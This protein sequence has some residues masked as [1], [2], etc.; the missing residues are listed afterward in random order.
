MVAVERGKEKAKAKEYKDDPNVEF[1]EVNG[2]YEAFAT[3]TNDPKVGS[4][5]QYNNTK[6]STTNKGDIDAYEAWNGGSTTTWDGGTTGVSST[7]IAILDTGIKEEHEDLTGKVTKRVNY[8]DSSTNDDV[9]GHGTHVAGSAAALTNN[10]KGV[11]GTCPSC[12]L[13]NVKV[14]GDTGSGYNSWIANGI[15]WATDNGAQVINMSLGGSSSSSTLQSAVDYAWSKGVIVVAAAGN[16]NTNAQHY[17]AAYTNAIAVG[18]TDDTD[19]KASFSNYGSSWVDVAAP[20]VGI[21]STTNDGGYQT[22][23]GTSMA[24]PHVAGEA[25]LIWS[26]SGLCSTNTCVRNQIESKADQTSGTGTYWAKGRVNANGGLGDDTTTDPPP[27]DTTTDPPASDTTAPVA[28]APAESFTGTVGTST[29]PVKLTW[30]ATDNTDGSGIASYQLQRSVNGGTYSNVTLPSATTTTITPSLTPTYTYRYRVAAKDKAGNVSAWAYGPS[31]KVNAYQENATAVTYPSGTWTR[32]YLSGAYKSYVK[33]AKTSGATA[34]L[35]FTGR[36]VAWV[37][38]K[39][40]TRGKADV[41]VDGTYVQTVDL[42]SS[43]TLSRRVVFSQSWADSG[44][45][46]LEVKVQGTSGQPRVDVDAFVVLQ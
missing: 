19:A 42:Y 15:T 7:A 2:V 18:A 5:W 13:Y 21:L 23:N 38:P 46:T 31:F 3:T 30:S 1:A 27:D 43:S 34:K 39:S 6:Y 36:D 12:A 9:H 25:G 41:Y 28:E 32:A 45:H 44:S 33:Y 14:L 16:S 24:T 35:S 40:S 26:K 11:A 4:Q 20:G 10:E 37:A 22:K 29:I 8:T 17:P